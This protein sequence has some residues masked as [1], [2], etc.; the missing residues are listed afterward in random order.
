MGV[1]KEA[2]ERIGIVID[3]L[4]LVVD[5]F[6]N[7]KYANIFIEPDNELESYIHP[8]D[9]S[10]LCFQISHSTLVSKQKISLRVKSVRNTCYFLV[11][12]SIQKVSKG[13]LLNGI[14]IE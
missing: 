1:S 6:N 9:Y 10:N 3:S 2:K 11:E 4:F 14:V 13:Y 7:T 12:M 5:Y 8:A